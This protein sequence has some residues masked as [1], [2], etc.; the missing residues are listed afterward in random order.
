MP[1]RKQ[2][3]KKQK[4]D[5]PDVS[6][7][8]DDALPKNL[9]FH[10]IAENR[11]KALKLKTGGHASL[12]PYIIHLGDEL[13]LP[14]EIQKPDLKA[15]ASSFI[16]DDEDEIEEL[17]L[18]EVEAPSAYDQAIVHQLRESDF[19]ITTID[20]M[21]DKAKI[22]LYEKISV[23][24][25]TDAGEAIDICAE[26]MPEEIVEESM[27]L[28]GLAELV[29]LKEEVEELREEIK[30]VEGRE[31]LTSRSWTW[32]KLPK[33]N[34]PLLNRPHHR[35]IAAFTLLSFALVLPIQAMQTFSGEKDRS[36]EI[37]NVGESAIDNLMRGASALGADR[38][39]VAG[40]DFTR[41]SQNFAQAEKSL[42][43]MNSA[44]S[45]LAS[46]I[47]Q[48]DRAYNS[49]RGLITAGR[50]L[51]EAAATL[52]QA[53]DDLSSESAIDIVTKLNALGSYVESALP[54]V[55]AA[56]SAL[57]NV[58]P[59]VI[60]EDYAGLV[61]TLKST[62]PQLALSM[63]EFLEFSDALTIIMGGE[64][65]MRY[66]VTFQNNTELR[67]T[68]GFIGSFAQIDILNGAIDEMN[69]PGGGAYDVQGQLSEF[70][71]S[72]EPLSLINPR[73][74]FH[75]SNWFADFPSSAKKTIWFYE[76]AG[77]PTVDG[78]IAINATLIPEL[79]EILGPVEMPGYGRTINSENFLFET[80]KIVEYE[81][82]EFA[83]DEDTNKPKQFIADLAPILLE[84]L[85][86]ADM[87][88]MLAVLDLIGTGLVQK[89]AQLY[90]D[91]NT[92]QAKMEEL[93]WSG[94]IKQTSGDYLLVVDSN[95]GGGKTD[96]II[97]QNI[98]LQIDVDED[99]TITNTLTVSKEHRG[100]ANA[101]FEGQNNV[102]YMR[103]YVPRGS[104]LVS[105]SGFEIPP[106]ELFE[107][108]EYSLT[109]DHDLALMMDNVD[110]D[111]LSG[112][113]IWEES[114]KTVFG[115]W[116]QTAPGETEIVTF[117]YILP[118]KLMQDNESSGLLELAKARLG[119]RN[120]ETYALVVQ[121]QSGVVA[122]STNVSLNLPDD[123][124][125][126][127]SSEAGTDNESNILISNEQDSL[128]QFL[129]EHKP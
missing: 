10:G 117:T 32:I 115:N 122:R 17:V 69:I 128:L 23:P 48:T 71:A 70:V 41:A 93:G 45:T 80:Q 89:D 94:S 9:K 62:T 3:L 50:N 98:D 49:A 7:I 51:S 97:D 76:K 104:T 5:A 121:K 25:F 33:F 21:P 57:E 106:V 95:L 43:D 127:W 99:G 35:A 113:D 75:D 107:D 126:I 116:V 114:G 110:R 1:P 37:T 26:L 67:A 77:G 13:E 14:Q 102:D 54:K 78:L 105:A 109:Y 11:S 31:A 72:P 74:E 15:L 29:E 85:E 87:P 60:P 12:S 81:Y 40:S 120:L 129:I 100:L 91:N 82:E 111:P 119:F 68:G 39:D 64:S 101:L 59:S 112:T 103:I 46:V 124:N 58:D 27:E 6:M 86:A 108:S 63:E 79:L 61:E 19:Q 28:E 18:P 73:W 125:V 66:L 34:T 88:T 47:P 55:Q 65:K 56:A 4:P 36:V 22:E 16:I 42:S 118:Y 123:S 20:E 52:A 44:I 30:E 92:L 24:E 2:Q 53:G 83:Q 90:F 38:F 8:F 84:R 96:T